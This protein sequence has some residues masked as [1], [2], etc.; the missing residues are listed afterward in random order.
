MNELTEMIAGQIYHCI[1]P[2]GGGLDRA[3][4]IH[5]E[6]RLAKRARLTA[7]AVVELIPG[8]APSTPDPADQG[9][10]Q[11]ANQEAPDGR[12]RKPGSRSRGTSRSR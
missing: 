9:K 3:E 7:V 11:S 2:L 6:Q 1:L 10:T 5:F 4:R 8:Q 12:Q